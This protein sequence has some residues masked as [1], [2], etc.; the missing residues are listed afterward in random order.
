MKS[1]LVTGSAGF[2]G[3]ALS[4]KLLEKGYNVIGI[5]NLNDYYDI[6]LKK[7]RL[8]RHLGHTHYKH[9][10][11]DIESEDSIEEIFKEN[12]FE[13]VIN[14]AAQ[15]GVRYSIENPHKYVATNVLGFVNILEACKNNKIKHLVYASSSSV[16]GLNQEI[17]FST[18]KMTNHPISVYASTKKSN[19]LLAHTYSHQ[20]NLPT[21]G[22]RFFT[23][24]GPWDRPDMALQQF[25]KAITENKP[26]KLFNHGKHKRDFTY[27]DDIV[28]GIL[29]V[30]HKPAR[31]DE[32]WDPANPKASSSSAPF[33]IYNIGNNSMVDLDTY[34]NL[35]EKELGKKTKRELHPMQPGDVEST[36]ADVNDLIEDFGYQP[37]TPVESGIKEFASWY[38][39]YYIK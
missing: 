30:I 5:D 6:E 12:K 38:K 33:R 24:Y 20:Y 26:I 13:A 2:I 27:I 11:I 39:S 17:P 32:N 34:V 36:Y 7:D 9:Y 35:L 29:K 23:V 31:S 37:T 22:L 3:S 4:L 14:L 25:A 10:E 8:A 19:E 16:Y 1:L 28:G 21:T 15:A 18:Q